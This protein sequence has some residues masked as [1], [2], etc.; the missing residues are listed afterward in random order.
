MRMW[1]WILNAVHVLRGVLP[2][3]DFQEVKGRG[4][5]IPS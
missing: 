4:R 3:S 2:V 1:M 5:G